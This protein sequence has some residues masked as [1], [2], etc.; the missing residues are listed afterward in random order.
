MRITTLLLASFLLAPAAIAQSGSYQDGTYLG[1]KPVSN[2]TN[3]NPVTGDTY[4]QQTQAFIIQVGNFE[5]FLIKD[6][7][8]TMVRSPFSHED[9]FLNNAQP[10]SVLH[11]RLGSTNGYGNQKLYVQEG[12]KEHG[13]WIKAVVPAAAPA[14]L[15]AR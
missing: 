11:V 15:H 10:G 3:M 5:Y 13:Y 4:N 7:T 6:G 2:G 14:P 8:T 1:H 9:M 12:S